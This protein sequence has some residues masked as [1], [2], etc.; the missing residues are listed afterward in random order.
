[1]FLYRHARLADVS[2][3]ILEL[4]K[5]VGQPQEAEALTK[6]IEQHLDRIRQRVAG[7]PRPRTLLVFGREALAL[8]GVYASGG[9]GFLHDMLTAAG[10]DNIFADVQRE[11][12]QA[13]S[14][15]I[16]ARRPD[17]DHRAAGRRR[18]RPISG[19]RKSRSGTA[20]RRCRRCRRSA[21]SF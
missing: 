20:S 15:L 4:G 9:Y 17:V 13:T 11:S 1:M 21:C 6:S 19:R 7:R 14:E 12:V 2:T 8:R 3:T 10:G 16:L 5:R 18:R